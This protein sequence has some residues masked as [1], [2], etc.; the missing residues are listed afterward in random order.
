ML[1]P[2]PV[3]AAAVVLLMVAVLTANPDSQSELV[4]YKEGTHLYHRPGCP[5]VRDSRDVVAMSRA[6][7][8]ARGYKP[9]RDCDPAEQDARATEAPASRSPG[10]KTAPAAKPTVVTVYVD[11]T[12]YYHRKDCPQLKDSSTVSK[13]VSLELAGKTYW[14]CPICTPP[15]R[16]K[17]A[18]PAVPGTVRRRGA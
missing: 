8:E 17:S 9:H 4:I 14:P 7:A 16:R 11:G 6:Q 2:R 10:S 15:V 3:R 12:K 5:L 1:L 13:P 18:E